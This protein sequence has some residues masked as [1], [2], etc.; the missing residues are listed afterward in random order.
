MCL[1]AG[2]ILGAEKGKTITN[3]KLHQ[4]NSKLE[5]AGHIREMAR[6]GVLVPKVM[7]TEDGNTL[8]ILGDTL[9]VVPANLVKQIIK[10]E[11]V[12]MVELLKDN[13]EA[14]R[15]SKNWAGHKEHSCTPAKSSGV[16]SKE[17]HN[18]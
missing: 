3:L 6:Q 7:H 9:P 2:G 4:F 18:I 15:S 14:E 16:S 10:G 11:F 17:S 1:F 8:F 13:M 5:K 12:D